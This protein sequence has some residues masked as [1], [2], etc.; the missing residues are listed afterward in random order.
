[1]FGFSEILV[2]G[3]LIFMILKRHSLSQWGSALRQSALEFK[4]ALHQ[5]PEREVKE[6]RSEKGDSD[7]R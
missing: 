7:V 2:L 4:K 6:Y 1:M 3:V 5:K